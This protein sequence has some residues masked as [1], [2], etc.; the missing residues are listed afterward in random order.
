MLAN[1]NC[2]DIHNI[3]ISRKKEATKAI[4][5]QKDK[6]FVNRNPLMF[7]SSGQNYKGI[8]GYKFINYTE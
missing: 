4:H 1:K 8:V 2:K 7:L 3:L 5:K 6:Y